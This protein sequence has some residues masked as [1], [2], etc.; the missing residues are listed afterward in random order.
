MDC[1][2]FLKDVYEVF[3]FDYDLFLST[4]PK[5]SM[6]SEELWNEAESQ[7]KEALD[8]NDKPWSLNEGDGAFYGPK[9]DVILKD[10]IGRPQQCG[11]IQLD[12]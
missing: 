11:T 7:L 1:L 2:E 12:F 6:G 5:D 8:A 3:D 4:R 10:A 9:I